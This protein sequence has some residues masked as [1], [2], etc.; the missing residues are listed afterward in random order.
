[1]P[2]GSFLSANSYSVCPQNF[3]NAFSKLSLTLAQFICFLGPEETIIPLGR[4]GERERE[5]E[6]EKIFIRKFS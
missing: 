4:K 2:A 6:R 1:V 3:C 5:R